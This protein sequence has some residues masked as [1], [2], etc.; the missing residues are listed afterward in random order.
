MARS[1]PNLHRMVSRWARI[2]VVLKVKVK[3]KGHVIR[4]FL[5]R[6]RKSL[7]LAGKW[8]DGD[9]TCTRWS[10][11]RVHETSN[12]PAAVSACHTRGQWVS[13]PGSLGEALCLL[14]RL[15]QARLC[16]EHPWVHRAH[17]WA[18]KHKPRYLARVCQWRL[19][20]EYEQQC[21][22][23][24]RFRCLS[25]PCHHVHHSFKMLGFYIYQIWWQSVK[26]FLVGGVPKFA[27]SCTLCRS[28]LQQCYA[29]ACTVIHVFRYVSIEDHWWAIFVHWW[30][31]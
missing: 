15:Q 29:T 14:L 2:Q 3:V 11:V 28:S 19:F 4:A 26:G 7:H 31:S 12:G 18:E 25:S 22:F 6:S 21:P 13:V 20:S 27:L 8:P 23:Y 30:N 17:A 16:T 5:S 24:S 1:L 10:D 9:Q